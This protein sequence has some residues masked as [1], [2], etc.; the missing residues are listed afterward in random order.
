MQTKTITLNLNGFHG[1]QSRRVRA[2]AVPIPAH[3]DAEDRWHAGYAPNSAYVVRIALSA[4]ARFD[5]RIPDC[6]CGEG[7]A[8]D[9]ECTAADW[10]AGE[11]TV[12]G[13][14]PQAV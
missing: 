11:I 3:L 12:N 8:T 14:Y 9:I 7:M 1:W 4:A 10:E 5:C 13:I 2:T 6:R